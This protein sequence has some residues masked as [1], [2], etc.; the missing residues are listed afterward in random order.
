MTAPALAERLELSV[1]GVRR[2]LEH[3]QDEGLVD[4]SERPPFGPAPARGRGRPPKVYYLTEPGRE[5]F[6]KAYDDLAAE[7]LRFMAARGGEEQVA[8]FAEH[9]A[10]SLEERYTGTDLPGLAEAMTADGFA[11]TAVEAK[12]GELPQLCQHHC[13]VGHVAEEF[14]QLCEAETAAIGRILGRHVIRLATIAHGDG[15]CTTAIAPDTV[16]SGDSRK[17]AR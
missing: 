5:V 1:Q 2:H 6:E 14:P 17:A 8:A 16:A 11:A 7:A 3:L 15:V 4:L 12:A 13:P 10:R 9:R